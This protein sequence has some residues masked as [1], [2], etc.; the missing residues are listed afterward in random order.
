MQTG[1]VSEPVDV[2]LQPLTSGP[3]TG[4]FQVVGR[5]F[6][7]TARTLGGA[8][9]TTFDPPFVL[10]VRYA[11]LPSGETVAPYLYFWKT[12]AGGWEPIAAT[13]NP[14]KRTLTAV[15]DHLTDFALMQEGLFRLYLP[16]VMD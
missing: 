3:A 4:N 8:P 9:V 15:L 5:L 10:T 11:D 13:H 14:E 7:I 2:S 6:Q 16:S 12:L 1:A